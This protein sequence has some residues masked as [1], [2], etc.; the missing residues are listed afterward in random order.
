MLQPI[1]SEKQQEMAVER[2][3]V[4]SGDRSVAL[5]S[6]AR[7]KAKDLTAFNPIL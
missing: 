5:A 3:D 6:C 1:L 2:S 4:E 7:H